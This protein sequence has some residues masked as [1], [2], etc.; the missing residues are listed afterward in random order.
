MFITVTQKHS[1]TVTLQVKQKV[2]MSS[3]PH[4]VCAKTAAV[5]L[6]TAEA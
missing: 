2:K 5:R 6:A 1:Y 3:G 4:G